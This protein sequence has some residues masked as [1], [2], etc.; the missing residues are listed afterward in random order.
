MRYQN[1][2]YF[3]P[4]TTGDVKSMCNEYEFMLDIRL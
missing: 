1:C 2:A 4:F 3:L